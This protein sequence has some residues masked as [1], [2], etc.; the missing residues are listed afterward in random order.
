MILYS[1]G[2]GRR[3]DSTFEKWPWWP[4]E[5][6]HATL[7]WRGVVGGWVEPIIT[8]QSTKI[9]VT[10]FGLIISSSFSRKLYRKA[11]WFDTCLFISQA[12]IDLFLQHNPDLG[13]L[14]V[15]ANGLDTN[16]FQPATT[17]KPQ[18]GPVMLF[19]G[20]M[21]YLPNEDAVAWFV[22]EAWSRIKAKY[23]S[24]LFYIAGMNPSAR[25]KALAKYPGVENQIS[26]TADKVGV[27]NEYMRSMAGMESTGNPAV[28]GGRYTGLYQIGPGAA[29]DVGFTHAQVTGLSNVN[30]NIMAA[31]RF[32]KQNQTALQNAGLPV[33]PQN[34]YFLHQQGAAGGIHALEQIAKN[35][36]APLTSNMLAQKYPSVVQNQQDFLDYTRGKF[37]GIRDGMGGGPKS[38]GGGSKLA[39]PQPATLRCSYGGTISIVD[40]NQ[41]SKVADPGSVRSHG[42]K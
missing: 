8:F 37:D 16:A 4:A 27:S 22:E 7:R 35:P 17:P 39:I 36:T 38:S 2:P 25:V 29:K 1:Q 28:G 32:A 5:R 15:I 26:A 9:E 13:R 18:P 31:A 24:A 11:L 20:V 33:T 19:T 12:E 3:L 34:L 42:S 6:S 40:P 14:Q 23:P 10:I 21:D 30:N 41:S